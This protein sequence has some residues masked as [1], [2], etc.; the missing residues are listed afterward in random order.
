M[1]IT[2]NPSSINR[3]D[4]KLCGHRQSVVGQTNPK[5]EGKKIAENINKEAEKIKPRCGAGQ[6]DAKVMRFNFA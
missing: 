3:S 1:Q 5:K 2:I 6:S 4:D